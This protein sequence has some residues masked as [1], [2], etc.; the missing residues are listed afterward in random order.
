MVAV[1]GQL[2]TEAPSDGAVAAR[3]SMEQNQPGS[4]TLCRCL[5]WCGCHIS[6]MSVMKSL[7]RSALKQVVGVSPSARRSGGSFLLCRRFHHI[8][9]LGKR[10]H[11]V[12]WAHELRLGGYSKPGFPGSVCA[13][14]LCVPTATCP[15]PPPHLRCHPADGSAVVQLLT[16]ASCGT[17]ICW[18]RRHHRV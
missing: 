17:L 5:I 11:I 12:Q 3:G 8:K 1:Q 13:H 7:K 10:K 14:M 2:H 18:C 15:A 4:A 9:N 6:T 16:N